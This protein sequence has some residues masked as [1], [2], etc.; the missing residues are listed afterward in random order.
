MSN[1]NAKKYL[2]KEQST[3]PWL[4][5]PLILTLTV[6]PF[7]MGLY[8]FNPGLGEYYWSSGADTTDLFLY[9]KSIYLVVMGGILALI[10]VIYRFTAQRPFGF[11]RNMVP[12][13]VYIGCIVLSTCF[14]TDIYYS[15]HG[16]DHH[17]ESVFV[18]LTYCLLVLY[19]TYFVNNQ[20]NLNWFINGFLIGTALLALFGCLQYSAGVIEKLYQSGTLS[21]TSGLYTSLN[22]LFDCTDGMAW[23]E[24]LDPFNTQTMAEYVY[25]PFE[26]TGKLT[27][28]FPLGQ[29]YTTLYNPNYVAFF[30]TLTAP[31]FGALA[32]F[33]KKLWKRIVCA[34][35]AVASVICLIGSRSVAGF[36]ALG[37]SVVI[38][39]VAFRRKIFKKW[40]PWVIALGVFLVALV[41]FDFISGHSVLN[42]IQYVTGKISDSFQEGYHNEDTIGVKNIVSSKDG[43]TI[44]YNGNPL[45]FTMDYDMN[46]GISAE[47]HDED[48]K[49]LETVTRTNSDGQ[50]YITLTDKRFGAKTIDHGDDKA[51]L[52][53]VK[54]NQTVVDG[55]PAYLLTIDEMTNSKGTVIQR[56]MT[57]IVTNQIHKTNYS[58][59]ET[60][61]NAT[62]TALEK[63][64][65]EDLGTFYSVTYHSKNDVKTLFQSFM[66]DLD[67]LKACFKSI[68]SVTSRY[69]QVE[70]II[71]NSEDSATEA[72]SFFNQLLS[73]ENVDE[74]TNFF[75][76]M[77]FA[78]DTDPNYYYYNQIGKWTQIGKEPDTALFSNYPKLASNRGFIWSRTFP[79]MFENAHNLLLGT[80]PD[81][82]VMHYPHYDYVG[83]YR[84]GFAGQI[85]TKPHSLYLQIATQTGIISLIAFIALYVMYLISCIKLYWRSKFETLTSKVSIAILASVS[86]YMVAGITN[87]STVTYAYVFWAMM[88]VGIAVNQLE[89]KLRQEEKDEQE[90]QERLEQK[91]LERQE[92]KKKQNKNISNKEEIDIN[93]NTEANV[94]KNTI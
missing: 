55:I 76:F 51:T 9:Y 7:V 15:I 89:K 32:F 62:L 65:D 31:F 43:I 3:S 52:C 39:V 11:D 61:S 8:Q 24:K 70:D 60:N 4:V 87:D 73:T 37:I 86:G 85:I 28:K 36:L 33:Q 77:T 1:F 19:G 44:D 46:E 63:K 27:L 49:A 25:L 6:I 17:F 84:C 69:E 12:V 68:G 59:E 41:G 83:L 90:R 50:F 13:Y 16:I 40:I 22:K 35:V 57:C 75:Y 93:A 34:V 10:F 23:Y 80:G 2:Q 38:L 5:L 79:I 78:S 64:A 74:L 56:G 47:F 29:V 67:S 66:D 88:G 14:S 30:T 48:G 21:K 72:A 18:L 91:R 81:T 54:L 26:Q 92:K 45:T 42:R 94:S 58:Y 71:F 20:R 53:P 82:Y